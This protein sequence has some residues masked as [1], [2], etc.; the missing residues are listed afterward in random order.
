MRLA[1]IVLLVCFVAVV[2]APTAAAIRFSDGSLLPRV[3]VIGTPY[4]HKLDGAAGCNEH[5][6][7]F[8]VV[9]GT[10]LPPG[11][12]LVGSTEDWRIEGTPTAVGAF[13]VWLELWSDCEPQQERRAQRLVT[14]DIRVPLAVSSPSLPQGTVGRPYRAQ[15]SATWTRGVSWSLVGDALPG[16]LTLTAGGMISGTPRTA[17]TPTVTVKVD[18]GVGAAATR[19]LQVPIAPRLALSPAPLPS[20]R[21]G[22]PYSARLQARG[23]VAPLRWRLFAGR[24]PAGLRFDGSTGTLSGRLRT[25]GRYRLLVGVTDRLGVRSTRTYPLVVRR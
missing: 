16:G 13:P 12:R 19:E 14:F 3:A 6:Y 21:A 25:A 23:G 22:R 15:L 17:G 20:A 5:D 1:K 2:A 7:E 8:A 10:T 18:P 11:L 24:L 4:F 9:G